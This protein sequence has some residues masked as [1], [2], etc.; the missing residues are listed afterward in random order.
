MKRI[1]IIITFIISVSS[2]IQAQYSFSGIRTSKRAG[3]LGATINPA[4]IASMPQKIDV[5]L[6]GADFNLV[7]NVVNLSSSEI[8]KLDSFKERFFNNITP[9]GLT[10]RL[11]FDIVGPSAAVAINKK[12]TVGLMTRGRILLSMNNIDIATGRALASSET[13]DNAT[14]PYTTPRINNMSM[15][16]I[17]WGEIGGLF[18]INLYDSKQHSLSGGACLKGIFPGGYANTYLTNFKATIDTT[19]GGNVRMS[20][21]SG[22]IGLEY[23]GSND[24]LNSLFSNF[25]GGPKGVGF[26]LGGSYQY[27]DK[28]TGEYILKLGASIV[29]IGSIN[30]NLNSQN[31]RKFE[32]NS[33]AIIDPNTLQGD[34]MDQI[35]NNIKTSGIATEIANDSQVSIGL[36]TAFNLTADWN[37]WKSIYL[38]LHMQRSLNDL[39]NPRS[40]QAANFLN[41]TPRV[42]FK[43]FEAYLPVSFSDIQGTTV[44]IGLK[45]GPMYIGTNSLLSAVL[46][47]TNKAID[48]HMGFRFALGK[49]NKEEKPEEKK[50]DRK[51]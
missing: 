26:D 38:T 41:F 19:A 40:L 21:S 42:S 49:R 23:S 34:D 6:F 50:A 18:A 9:D 35:I 15:N 29:D 22:S 51:S 28:K 44:G 20:N 12:M 30:F 14:L 11:N 13:I 37:I 17:G 4:E 33:S 46:S 36:P 3:I 2:S 1:A 8:G 43:L 25:I 48:M 7:N 39:N 31:S 32:L 10:V 47:E 16:L 5:H 24:P 27:K 45:L